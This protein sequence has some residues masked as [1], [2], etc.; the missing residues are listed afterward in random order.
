MIGA[1]G[2]ACAFIGPLWNVVIISYTTVLVPNELLGRVTSAAM[3]LSWGVMPMAS[4]GAGY[5][6]TTLGP[7]GSIFVLATVML[8]TAVIVTASPAVRH[9]PPLPTHDEST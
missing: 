4:L 3:T 7:V 6:L 5:L 1:I 9:A 2:A 8:V